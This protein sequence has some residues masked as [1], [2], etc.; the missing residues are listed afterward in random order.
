MQYLS[1]ANAQTNMQA[2]LVMNITHTC[3]VKL[4][5]IRQET[6]TLQHNTTPSNIGTLTVIGAEQ[7]IIADRQVLSLD[8]ETKGNLQVWKLVLLHNP[9]SMERMM[10][11]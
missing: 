6:E 3:K 8:A 4:S 1:S 5:V 10:H 2:N 9:V 11:K 7:H